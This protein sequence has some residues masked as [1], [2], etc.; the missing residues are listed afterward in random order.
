LPRQT[1]K[2][3]CH[4]MAFA[5]EIRVAMHIEIFQLLEGIPWEKTKIE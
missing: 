4:L 3:G 1:L 2:K 5:S